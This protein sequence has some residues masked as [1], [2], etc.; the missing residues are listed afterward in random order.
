MIR[1]HGST[2]NTSVDVGAINQAKTGRGRPV[3]GVHCV[4]FS[5]PSEEVETADRSGALASTKLACR[6]IEASQ[7][8]GFSGPS[9]K[10]TAEV[11]D[12]PR[13]KA[14][15]LPTGARTDRPQFVIAVLVCWRVASSRWCSSRLPIR[16]R[17]DLPR[18]TE[19]AVI[20]ILTSLA[21]Q[22]FPI[23]P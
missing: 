5:R 14:H 19:R 9:T 2:M 11:P 7:A 3:R 18:R 8:T 12:D 22:D 16:A 1:P 4:L 13:A 17:N 23:S 6:C 10:M 20:I 15:R 21:L